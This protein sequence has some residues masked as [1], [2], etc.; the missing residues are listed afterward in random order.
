MKPKPKQQ[1]IIQGYIAKESRNKL[2]WNVKIQSNIPKEGREGGIK[3]QKTEGT[4]ISI[5][6]YQYN[7]YN[8]DINGL[9]TLIKVIDFQ[10]GF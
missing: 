2:K 1:Q 9:N 8:W 4:N 10:I 5:L 6:T 3:E 7:K